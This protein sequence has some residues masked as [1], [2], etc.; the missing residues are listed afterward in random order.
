MRKHPE[1]TA[2]TR[3]DLREAFWS[4]Y[5]SRPIEKIT[6][7]E[8]TDRAGYNRATFYLYFHD[9]YDLLEQIESD[10]L[11]NVRALV[12]ERLMREDRL[13]FSQHM[14]IIIDLTQRY[15]RYMTILLTER[16]GRSFSNRLKAIL[17]PLVGFIMPESGITEQQRAILEEFYL[18]GLLAAITT[19]SGQ[20]HRM[21]V[22]GFIDLIIQMVRPSAVS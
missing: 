14:G 17:K 8:I 2:R 5:E 18:A 13:D 4:L 6:I 20:T 1:T 7:R 11:V 19:W 12:E 16:G 15:E 3:A 10:I 21:P 22:E 9:V